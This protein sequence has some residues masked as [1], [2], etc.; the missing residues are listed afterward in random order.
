MAT[1]KRSVCPV[2]AALDVVGDRWTLLVVR[3]LAC[4]KRHFAEFGRSPERIA[5]NILA[6]RLARLV[7]HGLAEKHAPGDGS[8]RASYRLTAKGRSLGPVLTA[9]ADWGLA[10][11][12]GTEARLT[13]DFSSPGAT[14]N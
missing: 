4:G 9:L 1:K 3:D 6:D 12:A 2:A 14:P 11:L 13:P 10:N 7:A 8:G 5:T